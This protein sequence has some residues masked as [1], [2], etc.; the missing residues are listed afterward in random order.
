MD[1]PTNIHT[2]E[3][4]LHHAQWRSSIRPSY[5]HHT[6]RHAQQVKTAQEAH[7]LLLRGVPQARRTRKVAAR[8]D[9]GLVCWYMIIASTPVADS[10]LATP[11]VST[12][13]RPTNTCE[14]IPY[15]LCRTSG[16]IVWTVLTRF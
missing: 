8:M 10:N 5:A 7:V 12:C 13:K 1:W 4:P 16:L 15:V 6:I 14:E 3:D 11:F 2:E 9:I